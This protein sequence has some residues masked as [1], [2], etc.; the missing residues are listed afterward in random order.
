MK[1][2]IRKGYQRILNE[3]IEYGVFT[4]S[5]TIEPVLDM[6]IGFDNCEANTIDLTEDGYVPVK[7]GKIYVVNWDTRVANTSTTD[8]VIG[9]R[10]FDVANDT[11]V[12]SVIVHRQPVTRPT[13]NSECDGVFVI[14]QPTS[15]GKLGIKVIDNKAVTG[16]SRIS[17]SIMEIKQPVI[18]NVDVES[19]MNQ[20]GPDSQ[21]S[22][23]GNI[24]SFMGT[25][26]PDHYLIC[27]G[28]IY[29]IADYPSLTEHFIKQFGGVNYF[30]GDGI[31]TF[32][33]PDLRGEFLRGTGENGHENQGNGEKVGTHQDGTS[34]TRVIAANGTGIYIYKAE[35][36]STQNISNPDSHIKAKAQHFVN[37]NN[38][39]T[40]NENVMGNY[41][42]RP[43]NTSVMW[44]IKYEPTYAITFENPVERYSYEEHMVGFW[45]DDKVLYEKT[46]YIDHWTTSEDNAG[47]NCN[48]E[49]PLDTFGI[50][51]VDIIF[52][53][54]GFL[55]NTNGRHD[56]LPIASVVGVSS[57][58]NASVFST[59]ICLSSGNPQPSRSAYITLR[60]TKNN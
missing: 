14:Y 27:D 15:D 46:I 6:V 11:T 26:A 42:S 28:S 45:V 7:A 49:I 16:L 32:A 35:S 34:H 50:E 30:G 59:K 43:T 9:T 22:P 2:T 51:N 25:E 3:D 60:Y 13:N 36:S 20:V 24:I 52:I 19:Y 57:N 48:R 18:T 1:D 55:I 33:V 58:V 53:K 5:G 56:V 54:E 12:S 4:H 29:N 41:T 37:G 40:A 47:T 8:A 17:L 21:D 44:C 31:T 10:L 23:V 38:A 39:A